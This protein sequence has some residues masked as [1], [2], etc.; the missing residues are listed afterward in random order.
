MH[1]VCTSPFLPL[2]VKK[3]L[4]NEANLS[5]GSGIPAAQRFLLYSVYVHVYMAWLD[6]WKARTNTITITVIPEINAWLE[7]RKMQKTS[8]F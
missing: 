6:C 1:T 4:V 8:D 2:P 5:P 7:K 3:G